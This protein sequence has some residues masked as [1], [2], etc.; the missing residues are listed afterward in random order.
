MQDVRYALRALARSRSFTAA[1]VLTLALGI[2]ANSAM[3]S[4]ANA[5]LFHGLPYSDPGRLVALATAIKGQSALSNSVSYPTF[6]DWQTQS[7]SFASLSAYVIAGTTLTGRSDPAVLDSAAV[8]PNLFETLGATAALGRP[9]LP[10]DAGAGAPNVVVISE[11]LWRD[12]LDGDP[13]V[14]G[15]HLTLDSTDYTIVGVMG[16]AFNF[17]H[18]G[19]P[20]QVWMPI[21]QSQPFQPLLTVRLAPFLTVVGRLDAGRTMADAQAEMEIIGQRLARAFPSADGGKTISVRPL[22]QQIVGDVRPGLLM[23][24]SAVALLLVIACANVANLEL[25]RMTSRAREIAVRTALGA[26]RSRIF[27]QLLVES[28]LLSIAGGGVGLL[29]AYAGLDGLRAVIQ[30][31]VPAIRSIGIDRWVIGFTSTISCMT[32]LLFGVFPA[33][34]SLRHDPQQHLKDGGRGA[35]TD[36][37][38]SRIHSALV[39]A[40]IALALPLLTAAGLL[41]RSLVHLQHVDPGFRTSGV[42]AATINLP[43]S[44]YR[45]PDQWKAFNSELLR[46]VSALPGVESAAYGVGVPFTGPPVSA[47]FTIPDRPSARGERTT[48]DLVEASVDYFRVMGVPIVRGRG[49]TD[50]DTG[51]SRPVAIVNTTFARRFFGD[52]D[53]VGHD[54]RAGQSPGTPLRIVGVVAD[55]LQ[56]SL[57]GAPPPLLYLPYAQR[58]FFATTFVI[59]TRVVPMSIVRTLQAQVSALDPSLPIFAAEPLAALVERSLAPPGHRT[60]VLGFLSAIA[61]L[62]TAVGIYGLLAYTV[63][64]RTQEIGVRLAIGAEPRQV[65]RLVL[66]RGLRLTAIGIALGFLLASGVTPLMAALLFNVS[67]ADPVTFASVPALLAIV[68]LAACYLPARRAARVDPIVALRFE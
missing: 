59:R 18:G 6:V 16:R 28:L 25:A 54:V 62:L 44:T 56:S 45:T 60:I 50:T 4:V 31:D 42:L 3:F 52:A 30:Q 26:T 20:P 8:T 46:R 68:S 53:P 63:A 66:G 15:Q 19:H 14:V 67:A 5:V 38:R 48:A 41:I 36:A 64:Q 58:P 51:T 47:P 57:S 21:T 27:R 29:V 24:L 1:A 49:F 55:T 39:V 2:G 9:L 12:R 13:T 22:K 61:L 40:E 33:L 10:A 32:G 7:R 17:P 11:E 37:G 43:R 35:T 23:L 34:V 65:L